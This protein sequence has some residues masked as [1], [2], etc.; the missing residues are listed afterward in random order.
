MTAAQRLAAVN[1]IRTA[2]V[3]FIVAVGAA[4]TVWFTA[5]VYSLSRDGVGSG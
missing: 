3:R 1:V 2:T 5:R 4:V